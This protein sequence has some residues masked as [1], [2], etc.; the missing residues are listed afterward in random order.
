MKLLITQNWVRFELPKKFKKNLTLVPANDGYSP[1]YEG[2]FNQKLVNN[3]IKYFLEN[4]YQV[5]ILITE[6]SDYMLQI[7]T[8]RFKSR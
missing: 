6:K 7:D 8:K 3:L 2:E 4:S 1:Y 5:M